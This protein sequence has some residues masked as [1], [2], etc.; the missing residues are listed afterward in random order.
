VNRATGVL[1]LSAMADV[2]NL[3][4]DA[5]IVL[6]GDSAVGKTSIALRYVQDLFSSSSNPTI[7]ASFLTKRV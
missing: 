4:L 6:L 5:K 2:P 7:G 1:L 3:N